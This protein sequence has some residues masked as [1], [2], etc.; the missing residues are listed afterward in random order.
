MPAN[1]PPIDLNR[2]A[3]IRSWERKAP[4]D[5]DEVSYCFGESAKDATA[6]EDRESAEEIAASLNAG[7]VTVPSLHG[8]THTLRNFTVEEFSDKFVIFC[9]GPFDHTQCGTSHPN[10]EK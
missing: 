1:Q 9:S 6:W 5:Y 2:K 3:Y 10:V 4:P 7:G 8:D